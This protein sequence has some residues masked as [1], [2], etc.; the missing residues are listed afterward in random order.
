[1]GRLARDVDVKYTQ[2]ESPVAIAR[3]TLAIDRRFKKEG[4]QSAD[5]ISCVA[6][7]KNGEFAE[8][9]L[10]KGMKIAVEGRIQTGSYEKDGR[11]IYTT[12]VV[13]EHHE[14]AESKSASQANSGQGENSSSTGQNPGV[15]SDGFMEIP[16][17]IGDELPFQ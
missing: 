5:F 9:Y 3:Y 17:G 6:F 16:D 2:G 14:F 10:H 11:K 8:K 4:Q 13:V 1:M 7:G 12:D 15:S